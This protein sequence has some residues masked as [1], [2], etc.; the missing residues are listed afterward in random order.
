MTP[1]GAT[2]IWRPYGTNKFSW[3]HTPETSQRSGQAINPKK[4]VQAGAVRTIS[5]SR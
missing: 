2:K 4:R 5:S 1:L 3:D